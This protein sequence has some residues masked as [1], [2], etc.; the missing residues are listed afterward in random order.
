ML[1]QR[2]PQEAYRRV[3]FDARVSASDPRQLVKLCY[4]QV[5]AATGSAIVAH[6]RSDPA[7]KSQSL[8]RALAALT[9]LQLGVSSGEGV[10][11]ALTQLYGSARKALLESAVRFDPDVVGQVRQDF[12]DIAQA[13]SGT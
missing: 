11:A 2:S 8:T 1:L 6:E 13:I 4:E 7:L 12:I 5:I 9:A 3:D 10:A